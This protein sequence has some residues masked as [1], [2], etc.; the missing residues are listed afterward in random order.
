MSMR[1]PTG[2]SALLAGEAMA[3][4]IGAMHQLYLRKDEQGAFMSQAD[5]ADRTEP[6]MKRNHSKSRIR[7]FAPIALI[8]AALALAYALGLHRYVSLS[9]LADYR[10]DLKNLVAEWP[11]LAPVGY[12][13][14]YAVAVAISFPA[15]SVLS[16]CAG[17]L[18][19]WLL[20]TVVIAVGATTGA[21]ALFLAARGASA[22]RLRQRLGGAAERFASGFENDAFG[23]LLALRLAPVFPFFVINIAP[24][25]FNVP[26]RTYV[27]ATAIGILPGCL[28][29]AWLGNGLDATLV[30]AANAGRE[31][32]VGDLVTPEILIAFA[33]LSAVALLG[34]LVSR[35]RR[36]KGGKAMAQPE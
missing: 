6:G 33:A 18:F 29:Y 24:A 9:A 3:V 17:L 26:L 35:W 10:D 36:L 28:A 23:Y 1:L 15:A 25:F 4:T 32:T 34:T 27:L 31:L 2:M 19:G 22:G 16:V 13:L 11:V 21:T 20:G 30:S 14:F 8:V 12:A 5:R 7:R